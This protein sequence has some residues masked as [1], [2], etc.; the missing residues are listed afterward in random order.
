MYCVILELIYQC[1]F[2][3]KLLDSIRKDNAKNRKVIED[4]GKFNKTVGKPALEKDDQTETL[5]KKLTQQIE[6][7]ERRLKD[8]NR[9]KVSLKQSW[10]VWFSS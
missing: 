2:L 10:M 4:I 6:D 1:L 3:V 7:L 8:I 9:K 5:L